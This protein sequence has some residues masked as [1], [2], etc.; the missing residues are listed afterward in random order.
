MKDKFLT[1]VKLPYLQTLSYILD[2]PLTF[3][4]LEATGLVHEPNFSII[5][6]G[7]VSI[8]P[9]QI[10]EKSSLVNPGIKIPPFIIELTGI[11]NDMVK[12]KKSFKHFNPYFKKISQGHI[13]LGFNS[14]AYDSIGLSK[15]GLKYGLSYSFHNQIDIRYLFTKNRN[16]L[17]NIKSQKGSLD[18]ACKFYQISLGDGHAHRAAY[19]IAL[20]VLLAEKILSTHGL[21][22]LSSQIKKLSCPIIKSNFKIYLDSLEQNNSIF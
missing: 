8:T 20:T 7:L 2:R 5:E 3:V 4:D 1:D 13:L 10:L 11:T 19:D 12:D 16:E 9:T 17:L 18:D 15:M 6:I 21:I 22:S 14:K